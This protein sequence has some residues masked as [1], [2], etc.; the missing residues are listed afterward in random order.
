MARLLIAAGALLAL[1]GALCAAAVGLLRLGVRLRY[2]LARD[3]PEDSTGN[4]GLHDS[5]PPD[6]PQD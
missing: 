4:Y 6:G 2:G 3:E 5:R 1:L